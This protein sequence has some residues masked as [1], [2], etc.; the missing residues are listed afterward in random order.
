ML[1][2]L[3][4]KGSLKN[5]ENGFAM[6]LKNIIDTGTVVGLGPL[7]VDETSYEPSAYKVKVGETE[8]RGDQITRSAPVSVRSFI[9][10]LL[11]VE[12][13]A[14]PAGAHKLTFQIF[15]REAGKLQFSITEEIA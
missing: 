3:Y 7:V 2:K 9:E 12:G 8:V 14:L 4:I 10:I 13:A 6:K 1:A 5:T 15:T 11:T